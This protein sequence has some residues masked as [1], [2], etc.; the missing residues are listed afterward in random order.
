ME[1]GRALERHTDRKDAGGRFHEVIEMA[2]L[3][4]AKA[5]GIDETTGS[6]AA[7][8]RADLILIRGN[9]LNIAPIVNS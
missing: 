8:K 9:D 5:L 3:N 4:G 1:H 2:T 7:G 6:I